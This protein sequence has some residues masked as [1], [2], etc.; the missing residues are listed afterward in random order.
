MRQD[1]TI[2][3]GSESEWYKKSGGGVGGGLLSTENSRAKVS[4]ECEGR[5]GNFRMC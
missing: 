3:S 4:E 1:T 5:K 2:D